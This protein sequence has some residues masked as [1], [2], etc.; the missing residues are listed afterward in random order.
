MNQKI[1]TLSGRIACLLLVILLAL[2][3]LA[4]CGSRNTVTLTVG[5]ITTDSNVNSLSGEQLR[6]IANML[7]SAYSKD[8]DSRAMLVAASRGYDMTIE[9]FD[10]TK[11][12]FPDKGVNLQAVKNVILKANDKAKSDARVDFK[13]DAINE[14]DVKTLVGAFQTTVD[15]QST[16]GFFD[17]LLV[18]I[19]SVLRWI[20]NTL[21]FGNYL[22][23]ICIFAILIEICMLPFAI[24]SS[25]SL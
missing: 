8:F 18:A 23:G 1:R 19:G 24:F 5:D 17:V 4:G 25:L 13:F 16:G 12:E 10:D 9:G 7:A 3:V 6:K 15:T 14:A 21:G 22:V 20:T 11:G 2:G